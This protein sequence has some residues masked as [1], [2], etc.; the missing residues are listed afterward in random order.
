MPRRQAPQ[1]AIGQRVTVDDEKPLGLEERQRA[2]RSSRGPKD[3]AFPRVAN[4]HAPARAVTDDAR[5]GFRTMVEIEDD[6]TDSSRTQ[7]FEDSNHERGAG[8]GQRRL[9][10]KIRERPKTCGEASR[11]DQGRPLGQIGQSA[12]GASAAAPTTSKSM[13]VAGSPC[14]R[15]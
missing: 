12:T 5:D 15:Q 4:L 2:A 9:G 13:S 6:A 3:L 1:I 11:Q 8:D 7:P 14:S 10:A